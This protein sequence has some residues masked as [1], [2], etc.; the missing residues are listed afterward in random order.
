[1]KKLFPVILIILIFAPV[2]FA[3]SL[4]DNTIIL[5]K[6]ET[7]FEDVSSGE[8]QTTNLNPENQI[9][10]GIYILNLGK[11]DLSTGSFT[12]DFYLSLTCKNVCPKQEF[13]FMNGRASSLEKIID[14]P[15][16]KFYRIQ[17]NL[18][19]PIDLKKFPFDKQKLE[20]ILEDKKK[21]IDELEYVPDLET[22]GIDES[23]S[24]VGWNLNKWEAKTKIHRYEIY[25]EDYS[26][27]V[28]SIPISRITIN[29]VFKTFL[30][31]IFILLVML[32]SFILDPDKITTRLAMVGSALV[33]SVMFHISLGNQIPPVSYLTFVDKFMVLTYFIILLSFIFNVFLLE[34][35]EQH[36]D[37]LVQKIH[38]ATEFT[39]FG[40]VPILYLILFIFFL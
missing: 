39:M 28:F 12:A 35:H 2:I 6:T 5:S 11:F 37:Q 40:L 33:A 4:V 3:D 24:F 27:Y 1:M 32:S 22:T 10:V 14:N 20:I 16:E 38:R 31:I 7:G 9:K 21:T 17:A 15:N 30:P 34:L 25:D 26:Q 8:N 29:A 19:S 13:E 23:I 18:V 36:K